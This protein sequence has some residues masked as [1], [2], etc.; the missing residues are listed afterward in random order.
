[1]TEW[2]FF[3]ASSSL[4]FKGNM[5]FLLQLRQN[6]AQGGA[7]LH[8]PRSYFAKKRMW[9]YSKNVKRIA[10]HR[11]TVSPC[12]GSAEV[13]NRTRRSQTKPHAAH[14]FVA[15]S[16]SVKYLILWIASETLRGLRSLTENKRNQNI[17][18]KSTCFLQRQR[19]SQRFW[20]KN[21]LFS[22]SS[23]L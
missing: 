7:P 5:E 1:M 21:T 4:L 2:C 12:R 14:I 6:R 23:L 19:W 16:T 8:W 17:K 22:T 13:S 9:H 15:H 20:W 11:Y 18:V 10:C 3:L